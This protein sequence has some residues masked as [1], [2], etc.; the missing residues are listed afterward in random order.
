MEMTRITFKWG[1]F[2]NDSSGNDIN[3][4]K[5]AEFIWGKGYKEYGVDWYI[6]TRNAFL[7]KAM[8]YIRRYSLLNKIFPA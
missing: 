1:L 5:Y 8:K 2:V 7:K 6:G 3:T 4:R